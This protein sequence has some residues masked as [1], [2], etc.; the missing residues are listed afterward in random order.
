MGIAGLETTHNWGLGR[1]TP[2][3]PPSVFVCLAPCSATYCPGSLVHVD[4]GLG[5]AVGGTGV[6][7]GGGG[8]FVGFVSPLV[9]CD[10]GV[11]VAVAV[12]VTVGLGV[13]VGLGV[14]VA[15]A[16]GVG[17]R[18][19]VEVGVAVGVRCTTTLVLRA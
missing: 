12:S 13:I 1:L 19:A 17:V 15:V 5:V 8:G 18:V 14:L 2:Y 6:D 4:L 9:G 16:V 10:L 3:Y 7:D 11:L